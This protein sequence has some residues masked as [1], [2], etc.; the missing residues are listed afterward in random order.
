VVKVGE[1]ICETI[2]NFVNL[3]LNKNESK[4]KEMISDVKSLNL[5]GFN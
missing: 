5:L 1:D 3:I 4:L 2:P